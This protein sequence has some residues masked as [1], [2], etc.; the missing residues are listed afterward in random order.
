MT[1]QHNHTAVLVREFS[2]KLNRFFR[3]Q[4]VAYAE[5]QDL[6]QETFRVFLEKDPSTIQNRNAFLW[7]IAHKKLL[8]SNTRPRN[9]EEYRSS[10][11][12]EALTSLSQ[13][14]DR[15][16]RV[17]ALLMQLDD[18]ERRVF[19]LRCEGLTVDEIVEVTSRTPPGLSRSTVNRRLADA[20]RRIDQLGAALEPGAAGV[21]LG[22]DEVADH[23]RDE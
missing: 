5:A 11:G 4:G 14:V 3:S 8:Q 13:R 19:L 9:Y 20:R 7:G 22:A 2:D 6:A 10:L 17:Q 23:Y 16:L 18:E 21:S 1:T 12:P 15:G